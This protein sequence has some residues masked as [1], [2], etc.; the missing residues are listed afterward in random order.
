MGIINLEIGRLSWITPVNRN[1]TTKDLYN[2]Q[3][4]GDLSHMGEGNI[5]MKAKIGAIWPGATRD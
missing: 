3:D 4:Q 5:K 2:V 1:A